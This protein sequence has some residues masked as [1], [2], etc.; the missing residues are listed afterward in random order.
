MFRLKNKTLK[1]GGKEG[2]RVGMR[3]IQIGERA[4]DQGVF[5]KPPK[6]T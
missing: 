3:D 2:K 6:T 4:F 5:E 1:V